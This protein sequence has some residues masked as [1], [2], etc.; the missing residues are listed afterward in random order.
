VPPYV[1]PQAAQAREPFRTA[2]AGLLNECGGAVRIG[3]LC[4][5]TE[6]QFELR[7]INGCRG[8]EM[9]RSCKGSPTTAIPGQSNHEHCLAA[10]LEGDLRLA[11]RLAPKYDLH[12][13][14][15]GE[16][17]HIEMK[18]VNRHTHPSPTA[19]AG[20]GGAASSN[21]ELLPAVTES[22]SG[23]G[24]G[25]EMLTEVH[26]WGRV[27]M[28]VGGALVLWLGLRLTVSDLR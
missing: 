10:D 26:T 25:W 20:A 4:R 27:A 12:F 9:D 13:P 28:V 23:S 16:D 5:S 11:H 1:D 6:R 24:S 8:R 22:G 17:W 3:N 14:V 21:G 19:G 7:G 15:P 18:G 2:I